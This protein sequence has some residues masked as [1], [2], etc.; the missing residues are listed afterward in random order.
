M[1]KDTSQSVLSNQTPLKVT[2]IKRRCF[3]TQ[4]TGM[5]AVCVTH[6]RPQHRT[7][8]PLH[9]AAYHQWTGSVPHLSDSKH[10]PGC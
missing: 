9:R 4:V 1:L 3:N 7:L 6:M 5:A 10:L 8:Q 2:M